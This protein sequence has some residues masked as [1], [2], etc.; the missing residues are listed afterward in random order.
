MIEKVLKRLVLLRG[1][2]SLLLAASSSPLPRI[3]KESR[4]AA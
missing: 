1:V 4:K 3:P 2:K